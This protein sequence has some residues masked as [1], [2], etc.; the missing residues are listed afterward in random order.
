[1]PNLQLGCL[2]EVAPG[3]VNTDVTPHI[4]VARV[5]GLARLLRATRMIT[6][7]RYAQH[8]RGVYSQVRYLNVGKRF[9]FADASFDNVF[10]AHMLEHLYRAEAENCVR[11]AYRVLRPGG[12]FRVLVP[13]LDRLVRNY[14]EAHPEPML[15]KIYENTQRRD[16]N[17]HHWMYTASSLANVL[18][19]AGFTQVERCTYRQGRCPDLERLDNRPDESLFMEGVK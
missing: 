9:P 13:D 4:W 19:G 10:S 1:M 17:R 7:D 16:K 2:G 3:W 12:V 15:Q 6:A 5:P 18:R 14:D 8:R 11:E